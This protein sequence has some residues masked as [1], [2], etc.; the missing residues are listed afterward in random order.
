MR[1]FIL[2]VFISI[3]LLI[4]T[5]CSSGD[6][7]K[8]FMNDVEHISWNDA[9]YKISQKIDT[10]TDNLVLLEF[11][12]S[13]NNSLI[14]NL[15]LNLI[16]KSSHIGYT[17]TYQGESAEFTDFINNGKIEN[18]NSID[19]VLLKDIVNTFEVNN[20]SSFI[21]YS[22]AEKGFMMFSIVHGNISYSSNYS[23]KLFKVNQESIEPFQNNET[24]QL[25]NRTVSLTIGNNLFILT[26]LSS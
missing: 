16:D 17:I 11:L 26:H 21:E 14:E 18:F 10:D 19:A 5:S 9:F 2:F 13:W 7:E 22:H 12:V 6:R 23:A 25:P 8:I 20:I 1:K 3:V 24:L 4:Q 15:T